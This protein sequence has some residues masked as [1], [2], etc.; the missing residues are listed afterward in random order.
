MPRAGDGI[1]KVV[2]QRKVL[3]RSNSHEQLPL[4]PSGQIVHSIP[5]AHGAGPLSFSARD[6]ASMISTSNQHIASSPFENVPSA[7]VVLPQ[8]FVSPRE[9]H[10]NSNLFFVCVFFFSQ[11][12]GRRT[13]SSV[14][15]QKNVGR[16]KDLNIPMTFLPGEDDIKFREEIVLCN[17]KRKV[18][19]QG[20]LIL[21]KFRLLFVKKTDEFVQ[22]R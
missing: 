11:G 16:T 3:Q 1:A 15:E 17:P 2:E 22:V 10:P 9:K 6:D 21:T 20:E 14:E 7:L 19:H 12:V 13:M 5:T 8:N 4:R 18:C